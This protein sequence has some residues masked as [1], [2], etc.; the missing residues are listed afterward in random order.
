MK[1]LKPIRFD[2]PLDKGGSTKPW[3]VSCIDIESNSFEEIPCVL[4]LFSPTH[5]NDTNCIAK[6]F[7]CNVLATQFDLLV[8]EAYAVNAF[9]DDFLATLD[10]ATKKTSIQDLKVCLLL[11][12]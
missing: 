6:E 5:V 4:K 12:S 3:L 2:G 8:P 7:L 9:E 11:V 1:K 10:T